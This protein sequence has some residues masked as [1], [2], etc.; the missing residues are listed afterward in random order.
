M[1]PDE[2]VARGALSF[3]PARSG[4]GV[5]TL[6]VNT[7]AARLRAVF[8]WKVADGLGALAAQRYVVAV[9]PDVVGVSLQRDPVVGVP[10]QQLRQAHKLG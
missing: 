8:D 1:S 4:R 6:P 5:R 9:R 3:R 7:R 10:V 2:H